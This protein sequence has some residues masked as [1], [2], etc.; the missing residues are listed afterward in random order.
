M[1]QDITTTGVF[2][3]G[4]LNFRGR[5]LLGSPA[6]PVSRFFKVPLL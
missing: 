5:G 2:N 4:G 6:V 3:I 1:F